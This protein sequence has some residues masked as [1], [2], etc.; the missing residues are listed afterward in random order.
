MV[1]RTRQILYGSG[2][3][4]KPA[5]RIGAASAAESTS[6][7]T[8]TFTLNTGEGAKVKAGNVL[9]VYD[10]DTEADAHVIYVTGISTDTITGINGYLGS[11]VVAGSDSGDLDSAIFEQNAPLDGV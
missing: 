10:P 6:G 1:H 11:P 4:E 2:L 3:G 5:I 8:V 9:S 7:Q